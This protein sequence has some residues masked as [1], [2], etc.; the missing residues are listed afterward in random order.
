MLIYMDHLAAA[1]MSEI[2]AQEDQTAAAEMGG[3]T[4]PEDQ[5]A[6]AEVSG[7]ISTYII[8]NIKKSL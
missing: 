5:T 3:T 2:T 1:E 7:G 4:V 8:R 6:A